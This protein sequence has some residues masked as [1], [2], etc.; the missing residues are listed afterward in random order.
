MIKRSKVIETIELQAEILADFFKQELAAELT[1]QGHTD[2]GRLVNS[3]NYTILSD[4]STVKIVFE[5]LYYGDIINNGVKA[6]NIPFGRSTGKK[7]SLYI[8][9]LKNWA[10]RKGFKN[11]LGAAFAIAKTHK[12]EGMPTRG[13]YKFSNNGRRK[14]WR[15]FVLETY[16]PQG[17]KIIE[18]RDLN[19]LINIILTQ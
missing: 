2:T 4:L 12:K 7:T 10:A 9:A 15:G 14:N 3:I 16:L 8:E 1:A 11:P 19:E 6:A 13:S 5:Y 17:L 18:E